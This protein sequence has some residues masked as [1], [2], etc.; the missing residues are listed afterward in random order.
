MTILNSQS[1]C[2]FVHVTAY[3]VGRCAFHVQTHQISSYSIYIYIYI[4][5]YSIYIYIYNHIYIYTRYIYIYILYIYV[6]NHILGLSHSN[7]HRKSHSGLLVWRPHWWNP[8]KSK[9]T[10]RRDILL[11][12]VQ[13]VAD[14]SHLDPY[15]WIA[16]ERTGFKP[17]WATRTDS[18]PRKIN[19]KY[20][21]PSGI[22]T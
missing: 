19:K 8:R 15:R 4:Q 7:E 11:L 22:L 21:L 16:T 10:R 18:S 9:T 20:H 12:P 2:N 3:G 6:Y 17:F 13:P 5:S 14:L 1:N